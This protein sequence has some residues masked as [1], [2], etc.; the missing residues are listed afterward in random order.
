M[1]AAQKTMMR[2]FNQKFF[3]L[4]EKHWNPVNNDSYW[5]LLT[6][7]AMSLLSEFQSNDNA[8]NNFLSAVVAAFLNSREEVLV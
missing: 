2:E 7:D 6:D 8:L 4:Q 5:D 1:T 3:A